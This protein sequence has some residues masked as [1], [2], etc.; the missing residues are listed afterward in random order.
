MLVIKIVTTELERKTSA[1]SFDL[2]KLKMGRTGEQ[3]KQLE[4]I[5]V[6]NKR[7]HAIEFAGVVEKDVDCDIHGNSHRNSKRDSITFPISLSKREST[8]SF[9]RKRNSVDREIYRN[10]NGDSIYGNSSVQRRRSSSD[11]AD[12][13]RYN[14]NDLI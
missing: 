2:E 4:A 12:A 5:F 9:L 8:D 10:G 3:R 13:D 11:K 1:Q 7:T 6:P 14:S